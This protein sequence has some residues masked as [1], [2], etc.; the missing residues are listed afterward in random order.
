MLEE[1]LEAEARLLDER[2]AEYN[3]WLE[4]RAARDLENDNARVM[5][6]VIP[7]RMKF[8]PAGFT[9]APMEFEFAGLTPGL[10]EYESIFVHTTPLAAPAG[11][12]AAALGEDVEMRDDYVVD[13]DGDRGMSDDFDLAAIVEW[14]SRH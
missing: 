1:D 10:M 7:R 14:N 11:A 8:E 12:P 6:N 3:R 5:E 13:A 4:S 2:V 9:P